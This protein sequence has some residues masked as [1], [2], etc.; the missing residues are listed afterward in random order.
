MNPCRCRR[1]GRKWK[2]G[3]DTRSQR[4]GV[5]GIYL[6]VSCRFTAARGLAFPEKCTNLPAGVFAPAIVHVHHDACR[7]RFLVGSA[8]NGATPCIC[9]D[10]FI[11]Y[12]LLT[13]Y[14]RRFEL[15]AREKTLNRS[16]QYV[17][18]I[19]TGKMIEPSV[20]FEILHRL[21]RDTYFCKTSRGQLHGYKKNFE[22]L[23]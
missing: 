7:R 18:L 17:R 13:P 22:I 2:N 5:P 14:R 16:R 11:S 6:S 12:A 3:K 10:L 15:W 23:V 20:N 21:P 19:R 4:R 8:N 1:F 9:L